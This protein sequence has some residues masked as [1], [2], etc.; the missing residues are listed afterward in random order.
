MTRTIRTQSRRWARRWLEISKAEEASHGHNDGQDEEPKALAGVELLHVI[1]FD[2]FSYTDDYN[3]YTTAG[4]K[5][6]LRLIVNLRCRDCERGR[7]P[8]P[9]CIAR[10]QGDSPHGYRLWLPSSP[11]ALKWGLLWPALSVARRQ[12]G[13]QEP[14]RPG[15]V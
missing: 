15:P 5:L 13:V 9:F 2:C 7:G 6:Q 4:C 10:R 14:T 12:R 1:S 8:N 11:C 3:M